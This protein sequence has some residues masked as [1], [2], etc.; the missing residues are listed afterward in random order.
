MSLPLSNKHERSDS[1]PGL[2]RRLAAVI[3][4]LFL[5]IALLFVATAVILPLNHG[6][7]FTDYPI[8]YPLFL[9]TLSFLFYGWFWTHGGQTLGLRA[10]HLNVLT[11][12][13]KNI[14]WYQALLRF[15]AAILSWLFLGLGFFWSLIDKDKRCWHDYLSKT[16]LF[17]ETPHKKI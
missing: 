3:Y 12:N 10:W 6:E 11:E 13:Q 8:V 7:A 16:A 17:F 5:L 9:L 2:L 1:R 15:L 14:N 4:D